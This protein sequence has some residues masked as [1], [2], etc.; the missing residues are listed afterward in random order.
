MSKKRKFAFIGIGAMVI[1][2]MLF[3]IAIYNVIQGNPGPY[4][5]M[6]NGGMSPRIQEGEHTRYDETYSFD[7]VAVGDVIV[8]HP[9]ELSDRIVVQRIVGII[10][11]V[12][13]EVK[14]LP[15]SIEN[16]I[17]SEFYVSEHEFV[18]KIIKVFPAD[19]NNVYLFDGRDP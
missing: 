6:G 10:R 1:I 13:K 7:L 11:H 8:F 19:E 12:S 9:D 14:T 15:D 18:G 4:L 2:A 17:S 5:I 16:S 3:G